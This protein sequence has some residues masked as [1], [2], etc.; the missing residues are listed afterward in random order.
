MISNYSD[1]INLL[2]IIGVG[3]AG[4]VRMFREDEKSR[5]VFVVS[6]DGHDIYAGSMFVTDECSSSSTFQQSLLMNLISCVFGHFIY[7]QRIH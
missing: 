7:A 2:S 6:S 1:C 3:G 4:L 5:H